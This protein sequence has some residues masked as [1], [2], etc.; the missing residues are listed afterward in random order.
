ML[1]YNPYNDGVSQGL[2][3]TFMRCRQEAKNFLLGLEQ[4]RASSPMQFGSIAHRVLEL[5]YLE[6]KTA[7][8]RKEVLRTLNKVIREFQKEEGRRLSPEGLENLETN[9]AILEAVLPEYF[10][11]YKAEFGA[12]K[13][14]ELEQ[15]FK[16]ESPIV[17]VP[18]VGRIDG[19]F[20]QRKELWL[21][22]SKTKGRIEEESLTDSLAFDFQTNLYQYIL[23][24]KYNKVPTGVLYNIIRRPGQRLKQKESLK[25][26]T[27]RILEEITAQPDHY[28]LRYEIISP[29]T[30][31]SRFQQELH[32]VLKEFIDWW[33]GKLPTYRNTSSCIQ[34]YGPCRFLPLCASGD[35]T[36]YRNREEM[37]PELVG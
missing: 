11:F 14:L 7:P 36:M 3:A 4:L 33:E 23:G 6:H 5:V 9:A 21:F 29:S 2:L 13:W 8:S 18:L 15:V 17:G 30:E 31:S 34:R 32:D 16:V 20:M 22:E 28:F 37:F 27:S 35:K 1:K 19:A 25:Q 12:S 24:K 10:K 26:F